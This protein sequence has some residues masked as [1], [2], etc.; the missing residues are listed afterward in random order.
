MKSNFKHLTV[1]STLKIQFTYFAFRSPNF[2]PEWLRVNATGPSLNYLQMSGPGNFEMKAE[3][4]FA[5]MQ[6]WNTVDFNENKI[7]KTEL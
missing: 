5:R 6:F 4:D 2:G 1:I 7:D 3:D